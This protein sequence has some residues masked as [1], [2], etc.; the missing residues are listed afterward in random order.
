MAEMKVTSYNKK[1]EKVK[2]KDLVLKNEKVY[3]ILRKYLLD[4][5]FEPSSEEE[6]DKK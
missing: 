2:T 1:G 4:N 5:N 3:E 6:K